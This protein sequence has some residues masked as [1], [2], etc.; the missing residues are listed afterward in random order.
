V[1]TTSP[2]ITLHSYALPSFAR[3][4]SWSTQCVTRTFHRQVIDATL[5]VDYKIAFAVAHD[6]DQSAYLALKV[7][8]L[9][10]VCIE[11]DHSHGLLGV[12]GHN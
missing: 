7:L 3:V 2:S 12:C 8:Q 9:I 5:V 1:I 6:V 11:V 10:T 4:E